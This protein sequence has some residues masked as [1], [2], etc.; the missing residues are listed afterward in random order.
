M[1][2]MLVMVMLILILMAMMGFSS[3][4]QSS[5]TARTYSRVQD[6]RSTIEAGDSA[7]AEVV[8]YI[9]QSMDTGRTT[10]DCPDDW[11][12]LLLDA[13]RPPGAR[14]RGMRAVPSA[15]R[16]VFRSEVPPLR[17]SDVTVDVVD[18]F[19]VP[20]PPAGAPRPGIL[21]QGVLE[22]T[23]EVGGA[24]KMIQVKKTIRQRRVFCATLDPRFAAATELNAAA[25]VFTLF[26][27]PLGTVVQ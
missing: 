14:P 5:G 8:V 13:L 15:S 26:T 16:E 19:P 2:A 12:T 11:R 17:I 9:R 3:F 1:G 27:H 21:P 20:P 4:F 22:F 25:A 23:V 18:V 7:I 10:A 6:M 24:Q